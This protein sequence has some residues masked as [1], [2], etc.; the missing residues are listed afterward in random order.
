MLAGTA[1]TAAEEQT[2]RGDD[3]FEAKQYLEAWHAYRTAFQLEPTPIRASRAAVAAPYAARMSAAIDDLWQ[4]LVL[5]REDAQRCGDGEESW[6]VLEE[7][8]NSYGANARRSEQTQATQRTEIER[9]EHQLATLKETLQRLESEPRRLLKP[10]PR[11][12]KP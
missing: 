10:L 11:S 7:L 2:K 12:R 4:W 5:K 3:A 8:L 9:L 6:G 1:P